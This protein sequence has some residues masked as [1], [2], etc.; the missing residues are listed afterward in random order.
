MI[1]NSFNYTR[2]VTTSTYYEEEQTNEQTKA[3]MR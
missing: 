3:K 2:V 1:E